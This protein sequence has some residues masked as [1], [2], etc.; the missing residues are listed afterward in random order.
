VVGIVLLTPLISVSGYEMVILRRSDIATGIRPLATVSIADLRPGTAVSRDFVVPSGGSWDRLR[1]AFGQPM[2]LV[3]AANAPLDMRTFHRTYN[4][5]ELPIQMSVTSQRGQSRRV[6]RVTLPL[7]I[8]PKTAAQ[9][10]P[11]RRS[12]ATEFI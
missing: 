2:L 7:S 9:L 11:S 1:A 4:A 8:H 3:A 10:E 12:R 6:R 5:T